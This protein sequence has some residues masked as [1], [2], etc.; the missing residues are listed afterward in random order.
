M[1]IHT[2]KSIIRRSKWKMGILSDHSSYNKDP[3]KSFIYL[4]SF[5]HSD[6]KCVS[7]VFKMFLLHVS[8]DVGHYEE[9]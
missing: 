9:N 3:K 6:E 2:R 1:H 7:G 8:Y 5:F 4:F